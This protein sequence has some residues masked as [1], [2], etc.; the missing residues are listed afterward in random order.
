MGLKRPFENPA[1]VEGKRFLPHTGDAP[2][3]ATREGVTAGKGGSF[4]PF[5]PILSLLLEGAKG[6]S[7]GSSR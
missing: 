5:R 7:R 3:P 2:P 6:F 1:S 4:P